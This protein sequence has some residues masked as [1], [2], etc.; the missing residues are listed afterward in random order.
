VSGSCGDS[1]T[2]RR[3]ASRNAD[4]GRHRREPPLWNAGYILLRTLAK[5]LKIQAQEKLGPRGPVEIIDI[6]C[7]TRPY[8]PIFA[9]YA[10]GYVGVDV[11]PSSSVD[12]V[13]RAESLP[14]DENSFDCAICTQVLEHSANPW[15][16]SAEIF[17]ILRPGG[18]AFVSTHGVALY[19]AVAGSPVDDSWRWTH[20]GLERMFRVTGD[21]QQIEVLSNGE[22]A[23]ALAY[24]IGREFE[25]IAAKLGVRLA[26][27]PLVMLL[28]TTA[29][30]ID[31]TVKRLFPFR[32]PH[33]APNYL[34]I[35]VR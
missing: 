16:V 18:V 17:R 8:E 2:V 11:Q 21:W 14:F 35:A 19:H 4:A 3:R 1:D 30:T 33:L 22:T 20:S 31:R 29:W 9:R 13:A 15:A 34:V 7:G 25:V 26:V 10:K 27:A 6:G 32:P 5:Q 24:L 12:V 28:N 23:S